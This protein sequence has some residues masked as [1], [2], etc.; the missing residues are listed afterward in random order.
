MDIPKKLELYQELIRC[1]NDLYLWH[2]DPKWNL[3]GSNCPEDKLLNLFFRMSIPTLPEDRCCPMV[4]SSV[5]GLRW[6]VDFQREGDCLQQIYV[7]GPVFTETVSRSTLETALNQLQLPNKLKQDFLSL[8]HTVPV[9][10]VTRFSEYGLMLHYCITGEHIALCDLHYPAEQASASR[11]FTAQQEARSSWALE[12]KLLMLVEE[13]NLDYRNA[14]GETVGIHLLGDLGNGNSLRNYKNLTIV[15]TA[16]CTRAAIRGG[17]APEI[18][19]GLS[20]LYIRRIVGSADPGQIYE[21]N[22]AMQEDF[23]RRVHQCRAHPEVSPQVQKCCYYIQSHLNQRLSIGTLA[24]QVGYSENYLSKKFKSEMGINIVEYINRQKIEYA[25]KLLTTDEL[26]I[27][28]IADE[29]GYSSQSYFAEQFRRFTGM[30]PGQ[31]RS[32]K[33]KK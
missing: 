17:L 19:Y 7:I 31:F 9:V 21:V 33:E 10:S 26:A 11:E 28:D 5:L 2:Y 4:L 23:I 27:S 24:S 3:L 6:F 30:S 12:Q 1:C 25:K 20:D 14:I 16:L 8:V 29:I 13:G 22:A 32:Q 15:F 18:A